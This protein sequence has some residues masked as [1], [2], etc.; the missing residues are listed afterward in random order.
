MSSPTFA[1]HCVK[2]FLDYVQYDTQSREDSDTFP[3]TPGQLVLA[4]RLFDDLKA[5]GLED[6]TL[7]SNGYVFATVPQA[8]QN[9]MCR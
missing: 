9:R 3:S 7:D 6:V 8:V 4:Q 5:L 2:R 1:T